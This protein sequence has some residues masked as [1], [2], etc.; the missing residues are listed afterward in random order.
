MTGF[1]GETCFGR[2]G[3]RWEKVRG[4]GGEAG[5]DGVRVEAV[6]KASGGAEG[7]VSHLHQELMAKTYKPKAVR[8]VYIEKPDGRKR[9]LG[10]PTVADRVVQT[11]CLLILEPI[12]EADFED[13]SYGFRPQRNAHQAL[14]EIR[15]HIE[16]GYQAV[17][18]ADLKSYFDSIP[19]ERL[20]A[21]VRV[22]VV[23]RSVLKLIRQW[24]RAAVVEGRQGSNG[25][26]GEM[27]RANRQGTP[28]GGVISPLLA[29]L[30]LHWFD[31]VFHRQ[32]G[33]AYWAGAKL[34]RYADDFVVLA[35]YQGEELRGWIE[36]KL[37]GW[38]GLKINR[39]K[40]RTLDLREEGERLNFLG[41]T[42]RYDRDRRGKRHRYLNVTISDNALK[43][44]GRKL[45]EMTCRKM[46][47]KPLPKLI[48][49]VNVHLRGWANY[50][51]YGYPGRG[52]RKI[53]RYVRER[54]T[55]HAKRKSQRPFRPPQGVSYYEQFKRMGLIYL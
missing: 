14:A 52:F 5:V 50:Y 30:Y 53:N 13:C 27:G 21:C 28:Q 20:L 7:L 17:Y 2:R 38:M 35:R 22:R 51:G 8:R 44:E 18:D 36:S 41:Y 33:P 29:N 32:T 42:F 46:C 9:A 6:E 43:R 40:T 31:K 25:G 55:R 12:F 23:D 1:I 26:G 34:V 10:I 3:R 19:H 11:A 49:E 48:G 54:L 15:R 4:N 47:F 45:R 39:D 24:L 37:E 16:A